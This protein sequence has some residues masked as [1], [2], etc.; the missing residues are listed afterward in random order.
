MANRTTFGWVMASVPA[1]DSLST[2][3]ATSGTNSSTGTTGQT[4]RM[5][6]DWSSAT[7]VAPGWPFHQGGYNLLYYFHAINEE[8]KVRTFVTGGVHI[9]DSVLPGSAAFTRTSI[10][11]GFNVGAGVKVRISTLFALRFDLRQYET[12]KPNWGGVL[13]NQG[14]LLHQTEASAGFGIYF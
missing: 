5:S 14:S 6:L 2:L 3:P 11:P 4:L 10:K 9:N 12:A 1:F 13:A 7:P 8:Q